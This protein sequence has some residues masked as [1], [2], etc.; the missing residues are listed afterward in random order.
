VLNYEYSNKSIALKKSIHQKLSFLVGTFILFQN[1]IIKQLNHSTMK[2]KPILLVLF[3]L[4]FCWSEAKA[5]TTLAAGD[6]MFSGVSLDGSDD[7]FLLL[8]EDI[9]SGTEIH[10]S[11]E[12]YS[13]ATGFPSSEGYITFTATTD[14][15][16]GEQIL[17]PT[18][19]SN[20]F[21]NATIASSGIEV[22]TLKE[23]RNFSLSSSG[24]NIY[25]FQGTE[26]SPTMITM[27]DM[28]ATSNRG[29]LPT[30]L[31]F[32]ST[33]VNLVQGGVEHDNG[34]YIGSLS[35]KNKSSWQLLLGNI[36]AWQLSNTGPYTTPNTGYDIRFPIE[37]LGSPEI[38]VQGNGVSIVSGD[39]SPTTS[40][41]TDFGSADTG[42][43][44]GRIFTVKNI[45]SGTLYLGANAV[46][47]SGTHASDFT[48][49]AQPNPMIG[50]N[51]FTTFII[52]FTPSG[53]GARSATV[54]IANNDTDENPYTFKITGI[55][56]GNL[57]FNTI[58]FVES[59]NN[60]GTIS[61]FMTITLTD[62]TFTGTNGDEFVGIDSWVELV[63]GS[64]VKT[65]RAITTYQGK[66]YVGNNSNNVLRWNGTMWENLTGGATFNGTVR[67]ITEYNGMLYA[68]GGTKVLKWNGTAWENVSGGESHAF[69]I[70]SLIVYNN[71]LYAGSYGKVLK[72][73][74]TAWENVSGGESHLFY[75]LA[76]IEYNGELYAGSG[77]NTGGKVLKWNGNTWNLVGTAQ[78]FNGAASSLKEYNGMLYAGSKGKIRKWNG[79]SWSNGLPLGSNETI[80]SME[81]YNNELYIGGY[82]RVMKQNGNTWEALN[83][84]VSHVYNV[85]GL[86]VFNNELYSASR[87]ALR[88]KPAKLEVFNLPSGLTASAKRL[89]NTQLGVELKGNATNHADNADI[90]NLTFKFGDKAFTSNCASCITNATKNDIQVEFHNKTRDLVI[91]NGFTTVPS[92]SGSLDFGS[93]SVG[94]NTTRF[95]T[96]QNQ[97]NFFNI[98]LVG[99]KVALSNGANASG[100][101]VFQNL[102]ATSL[103]SGTN[104]S[105][106]LQFMPTSAGTKTAFVTVYS[107]DP[108][109]PQYT[110]KITGTGLGTLAFNTA[111]FVESDKNDG[112]MSNFMTIS[113]TDDTFTGTNG[114]EFLGNWSL[115]GNAGDLNSFAYSLTVWNNELYTTNYNQVQKW[116]GTS[117]ELLGNAGD[118][119]GGFILSSTVW[120]NELYIGNTSKVYKWDGTNWGVVGSTA[121]SN[122]AYSLIV[123]NN[124]LYAGSSGKVQKWNGTS[125]ELVG[126]TGDF[127]DSVLSLA[128]WNNELYAGS[129]LYP[130]N[131]GQVKKWNGTSWELVGNVGDLNGNVSSL[132]VWNNVLY[133]GSSRQV[134]KWN[135]TS[136]ELVGS[137]GD[138]NSSVWSLTVWNNEFYAGGKGQ[139][140]KWNGTSWELVEGTGGLNS[141]VRSLTVWNNELYA[142]SS[143]Q[144]QKLKP[145]KLVVSNI[146]AGLIA[147]AKRLNDT[148]L[149]VEFKGNAT[150]HADNA[151]ISNLT[152]KFKDKAFTSECASCITNSNK[153]DIKVDF[154]DAKM[155]VRQ[156]ATTIPNRQGYDFGDVTINSNPTVTFTI[157]NA[158]NLPLKLLD[159]KTSGAS[160]NSFT[161]TSWGTSVVNP[162]GS[163]TFTVQLDASTLGNKVISVTIDNNS[164]NSKPYVF[165]LKANV[166]SPRIEVK[167]QT[168]VIP[169]PTGVY[170]FMTVDVNSTNNVT[171]TI[172]NKG[173]Q[174]LNL[175][176]F[177]LN[178]TNANLFT[179]S[180]WGGNTVSTT[181]PRTFEVD[182]KP[183]TTGI[184]TAFVTIQSNSPE[185]P[186]YYFTLQGYAKTTMQFSTI[187]FQK[188][189][190]NDG[191]IANMITA[192]ISGETFTGTNGDDLV[193]GGKAIV[194]N[195]PT[196]LTAQVIR[197]SDTEV[198]FRL[199]GNA[200]ASLNGNDVNDLKIEFLDG[201]FA[202]ANANLVKNS[203]KENM[204]INFGIP[205]A[206]FK[207]NQGNPITGTH[208]LNYGRIFAG[209]S[210]VEFITI[211][212]DNSA[213]LPLRFTGTPKVE[214]SGINASEFSVKG[215]VLTEVPIGQDFDLQIQ[216]KPTSA[217]F[218]T[219]FITIQH[220][221]G[222]PFTM[223]VT[224]MAQGKLLFST[225]AF[226]ES[227]L[228]TGQITGE[229]FVT[230]TGDSFTGT[231]NENM[232]QTNK[233]VPTNL[234]T[235]M[236]AQVIRL[237]NAH[238]RMFITGNAQ[239]HTDKDKPDFSFLFKDNAFVGAATNLILDSHKEILLEFN[240]PKPEIQEAVGKDFY[241]LGTIATTGGAI[242]QTLNLQNAS[243]ATMK[244]IRNGDFTLSN[245]VDNAFSIKT[246]PTVNQLNAG[247]NMSFEVEFNPSTAGFKTAF[248]TVNYNAPQPYYF[249]LTGD[250]M[251]SLN[252]VGSVFKEN[253]FNIGS[254]SSSTT[255]EVIDAQF[256]GND[257][258]DFVAL[259]R[260]K[261]KNLPTGLSL[262]AIRK[263]PTQMLLKLGGNTQN[264]LP[265]DNVNNVTVEFL[266]N[267]FTHGQ[268]QL[269]TSQT[270]KD[271][272]I[273]FITGIPDLSIRSAKNDLISS[274]SAINFGVH[275]IGFSTVRKVIYLENT[276]TK[277]VTLK[278]H[279]PW[280]NQLTDLVTARQGFNEVEFG[281]T[282]S[283]CSE[284]SRGGFQSGKYS[285]LSITFFATAVGK[286]TTFIT[287]NS[288]DP[289]E[290]PYTIQLVGQVSPVPTTSIVASLIPPQRP[291]EPAPLDE[292]LTK[293]LPKNPILFEIGKVIDLPLDIE[294]IKIFYTIAEGKGVII[295]NKLYLQGRG[296]I[297]IIAET[298]NGYRFLPTIY[299]FSVNILKGNQT[300]TI[301]DLKP[302]SGVFQNSAAFKPDFG[303]EGI[304]FEIIEGQEFATVD[305]NGNVV[306]TGKGV[307][308][309]KLKIWKS[310]TDDFNASETV[311]MIFHVQKAKQ[312]IVFENMSNRTFEPSTAIKLKATA[313]SGLPVSFEAM[314]DNIEIQGNILKITKGGLVKI[315]AIQAGN[316]L[317]H[318]APEE[319][320]SFVVYKQKQSI[321]FAEIDNKVFGEAPFN[322]TASASSDLPV[323]FEIIIGKELVNIKNGIVTILQAG[324]VTIRAVQNG[325]DSYAPAQSVL[326]KF[327]IYP[328]LA[329]DKVDFD[330]ES[331]RLHLNFSNQGNFGLSNQFIVQLSNESGKFTQHSNLNA[332]FDF[333]TNTVIAS[334]PESVK[335]SGK[336]QVRIVA[337][338]PQT[339]SN[340]LPVEI[341]LHPKPRRLS[342]ETFIE[343]K[344]TI[345]CASRELDSYQWYL[346]NAEGAWEVIEGA[347]ERCLDL[348]TLS[349]RIE[350]SSKVVTVK[351]FIGNRPSDFASPYTYREPTAGVLA[352][353]SEIVNELLLYP[354]P[355]SGQF[356][357]ELT[358]K[359]AGD[360]RMKLVDALGK[361][362][363]SKSFENMPLRFTESFDLQKLTN[364]IYFLHIETPNGTVVRKIVKK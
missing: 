182:F 240:E 344:G 254:S 209:L 9:I 233:I 266:G 18:A 147:S 80:N 21:P 92:G 70:T 322:L 29:E 45:A 122:G 352:T 77:G 288:D 217:G 4:T 299:N 104:E 51:R 57:A 11:D 341:T 267:A 158:G 326:Q 44:T 330:L 34:R 232:A 210:L 335:S 66:L 132:T 176:Q 257:N 59:D 200:T 162:N 98:D 295:G 135:G 271:F 178:G 124:E 258:E 100:F 270:K 107:N 143:G 309:V 245:S 297:Q 192:T 246:Q 304:R 251:G 54:S 202:G 141:A 115:L 146:P 14:I 177:F 81:V 36:N 61:T 325:D 28:E 226:K 179:T 117:W 261:V 30:G 187:G 351:G 43:S 253:D 193:A 350:G 1:Q 188:S 112:S 333:S 144:V 97:G 150:N 282:G 185:K 234:P 84:G 126:N 116:N 3:L 154:K 206:Q 12:D 272:K 76:L 196:G 24:E 63:G 252:F 128:I 114:D 275:T 354:N 249:K 203:T 315:K 262:K 360:V 345:I 50:S 265:T 103:A 289:N 286:Y 361:E 362:S 148:Q 186:N 349:G 339:V 239:K 277:A 323:S 65:V 174:T 95:L 227:I 357:L 71:E 127:N 343:P 6:V 31:S 248:L 212:N 153:N 314:S 137:A 241:H 72:W 231:V 7:I 334:I 88:L 312:T 171:F 244:F 320:R 219:A 56:V 255:V 281:C 308:E 108:D 216:F 90:S 287:I 276:G 133:A 302:I 205:E 134:Q 316:D 318:P 64:P 324:S 329:L 342:I 353:E 152:F 311:E 5:Q 111:G 16:K 37:P 229:V 283:D 214:I 161:T 243:D 278:L 13:N 183:T 74:G 356:T 225:S 269:M 113:L 166:V 38:D 42:T 10:I 279:D 280:K 33:A 250:A 109:T 101:S 67:G 259:N 300:L 332:R 181:N 86:T 355:T 52:K 336:Y 285:F 340:V 236:T 263:S 305:A 167:K 293:A 218:K 15:G 220:T 338:S 8:L 39:I 198:S 89:N 159:F 211:S 230:V 346:R 85:Y 208:N 165:E 284:I 48:V 197:I 292:H 321:I 195:V 110:F 118:L 99:A 290:N 157:D 213:T 49:T 199:V 313:T 235:G 204:I 145:S 160:V 78:G 180:S 69:S 268:A 348:S 306:P 82:N 221:D 175:S 125:W 91:H 68:G 173:N 87:K 60:D 55:G 138:L 41:A 303:M 58:G 121:N 105:F 19:G 273:E 94:N 184:K 142:G 156:G 17:I 83:D 317:Y 26:A 337:S 2:Q 223:E 291:L 73:N 298:K 93:V 191:S 22:G 228:N 224:G 260:L 215:D 106:Q 222:A 79:I 136:W 364:G 123:W 130:R 264:H 139:V 358:L 331:Y 129:K 363:Y 201:A 194:T 23:T 96:A 359:K 189:S 20:P 170:N 47:I 53:T 327:T 163:T 274:G 168:T 46:S 120:N 328:N 164:S 310:E 62:D 35:S 172:E 190:N 27:I 102:T 237:D 151:D 32:G 140:Y 207:D 247:D 242:T 238:L 25:I 131:Q 75:V 319:I 40:D 307:G 296:E 149:G 256:T 119:I 169:H 301:L 294:G 347:T 155:T